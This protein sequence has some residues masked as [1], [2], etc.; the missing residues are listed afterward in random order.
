MGGWVG[1]KKNKINAILNFSWSSVMLDDI[2]DEV[3]V[4][5][6]V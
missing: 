4:E 3:V 2:L 5:F 6:A 1:E